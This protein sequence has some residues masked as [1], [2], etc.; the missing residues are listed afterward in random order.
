MEGPAPVSRNRRPDIGLDAFGLATEFQSVRASIPIEVIAN[1]EL[2]L[3]EMPRSRRRSPKPG[4]PGDGHRAIHEAFAREVLEKG[5]GID[6]GVAVLKGSGKGD[7]RRL[8]QISREDVL[9]PDGGK[10]V[11]TG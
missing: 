9:L 5:I 3:Y 7:P 11:A 1:G 6:A 4:K 10:L 8:D 2:I